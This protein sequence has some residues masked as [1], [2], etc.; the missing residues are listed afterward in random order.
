MIAATSRT[1]AQRLTARCSRTLLSE[2]PHYEDAAI[3]GFGSWVSLSQPC[4]PGKST[5]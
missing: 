4:P 5:S 1:S 2:N 3:H